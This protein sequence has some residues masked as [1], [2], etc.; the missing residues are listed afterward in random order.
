MTYTP[1]LKFD[2]AHGGPSDEATD[3]TLV[4]ALLHLLAKIEQYVQRF[5]R[6]SQA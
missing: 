1:D 2:Q 5:D 4:V 6:D 3:A